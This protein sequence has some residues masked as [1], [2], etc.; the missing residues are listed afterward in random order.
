MGM[1]QETAEGDLSAPTVAG[2]HNTQKS[3]KKIK[4]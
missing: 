2:S 3:I 4:V 1:V